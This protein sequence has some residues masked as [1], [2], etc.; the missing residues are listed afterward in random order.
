MDDQ[1]P[2]EVTAEEVMAEIGNMQTQI[3]NLPVAITNSPACTATA[4]TGCCHTSTATY[5]QVKPTG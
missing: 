4:A 5:T 3:Q 1:P 2:Q